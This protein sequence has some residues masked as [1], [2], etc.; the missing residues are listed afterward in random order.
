MA[1]AKS[2]AENTVLQGSVD[3]VLDA[4]ESLANTSDINQNKIKFVKEQVR[5]R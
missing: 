1:F 3:S 4:I 2:T 5:N